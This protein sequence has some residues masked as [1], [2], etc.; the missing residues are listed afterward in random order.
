MKKT[1]VHFTDSVEFGGAEKA[2][3]QLITGL[4]R[5]RWLPVLFYHPIG[6]S[7]PWWV[8]EVLESGLEVRA[9]PPLGGRE[10]L[11]HWPRFLGDL[12]RLRPAVFHAHLTWPLACTE[13]LVMARLMRVPVKTATMQ[14]FWDIPYNAFMRLKRRLVSGAVD[15]YIAVSNENAEKMRETF[16]VPSER[17][18]TIYN[19]VDL[20]AFESP[21]R[22]DPFPRLTAADHPK[23]PVILTSA[24]LTEQKGHTY[25]LDAAAEVPQA[26]F[27]VAGDGP[28]R[29]TLEEKARRLGISDRVRFLGFRSDIPALLASCD[30]FVLPSLYEGFPLAVLEALAAGKPV[31]ATSAGGVAEIIRDGRTGLLVPPADPTALAHAIR[32]I[33]K[34]PLRARTM[35]EAGRRLVRLHYSVESMVQSVSA[36]YDQLLLKSEA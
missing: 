15:R 9:V 11:R 30:V 14:L 34:E 2:L 13:A 33:L 27:L 12:H 25:L 6:T 16:G 7:M 24:R 18:A 31:V 26:L 32:R 21:G 5:E 1:V 23:P 3:V 8:R 4:D 22:S 10:N 17:I 35:A 20:A 19:A 29:S 36:L 28:T